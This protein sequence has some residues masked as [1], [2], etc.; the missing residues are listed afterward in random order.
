[1][2]FGNSYCVILQITFFTKVGV[3]VKASEVSS[4]EYGCLML[5]A[6]IRMC[7][8]SQKERKKDEETGMMEISFLG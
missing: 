1:M 6:V 7:H 8:P 4:Q 2:H 5:A 3:M